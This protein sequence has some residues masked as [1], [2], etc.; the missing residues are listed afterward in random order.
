MQFMY[1]LTV[2][3]VLLSSIRDWKRTVR[4]FRMAGKKLLNILPTFL[5]ML[6]LVS[7]TLTFISDELI[8]RHIGGGGLVP[9]LTAAAIGTVTMMPGFVAFPLCGIL[10][11]KG[12]S[13]MTLAAFTTIL[14]M[15]GV[16]SWP[17]E[18]KFLGLKAALLHNFVQN[19]A[20][21][22]LVALGI[23]LAFGELM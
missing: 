9:M 8:M 10:L 1:A 11:Q 5:Y 14:M 7:I 18:R 13:Y 4:A 19:M 23:G 20:I 6:I 3:A 12:V 22:L 21:A 17:V 16:E 15:V 2:A